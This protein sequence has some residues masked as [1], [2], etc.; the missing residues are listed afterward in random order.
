LG[1]CAFDAFW[2]AS[3]TE[4]LFWSTITLLGMTWIDCGICSIGVA[5]LVDEKA[6]SAR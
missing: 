6:D 2:M 1:P 4:R 3:V 5:V